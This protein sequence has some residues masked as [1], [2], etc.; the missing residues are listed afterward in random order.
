MAPTYGQRQ[1]HFLTVQYRADGDGQFV[2]I[3]MGKNVA[4]NL[5][6]TLEARTG[7]KIERVGG[8]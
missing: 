7:Q 5:I 6:A 8:V 2:E 4:P 3:E 1:Q